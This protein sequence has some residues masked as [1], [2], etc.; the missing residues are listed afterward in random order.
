MFQAVRYISC[1]TSD[2]QVSEAAVGSVRSKEELKG[3]GA[4]F[5]LVERFLT[6]WLEKYGN[7][8]QDFLGFSSNSCPDEEEKG[9]LFWLSKLTVTKIFGIFE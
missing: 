8:R 6:F 1:Q 7:V 9:D 3:G 4:N 5:G 2:G